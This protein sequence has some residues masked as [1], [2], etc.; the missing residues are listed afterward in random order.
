MQQKPA[1]EKSKQTPPSQRLMLRRADRY[2]LEN[3]K[4]SRRRRA[5]LVGLA[6][7]SVAVLFADGA[8]LGVL[9]SSYLQVGQLK[10]V[11]SDAIREDVVRDLVNAHFGG[12]SFWRNVL[13]RSNVMAWQMGDLAYIAASVPAVASA[14]LEKRGKDLVVEVKEREPVGIWCPN[15]SSAS[16]PTEPSPDTTATVSRGC[17]WF[18]SQGNAYKP[19]LRPSGGLVPVLD[20]YPGQEE[21]KF[22]NVLDERGVAAIM[23]VW[24]VLRLAGLHAQNIRL[25]SPQ[26]EEITVTLNSGPSLL[27]SARL[28]PTYALPVIMQLKSEGTFNGLQYLDFRVQNR[29]YYK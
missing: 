5:W 29:A 6:A 19:A 26:L 7:L 25:S 3:K 18:D 24:K 11:G 28:D 10:V 16:E 21:G 9:K 17:W 8:I 20:G 13:G 15:E 12:G 1:Q 2:F 27:F 22:K 4:R 23:G 14:R